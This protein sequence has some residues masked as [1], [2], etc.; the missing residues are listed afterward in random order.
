MI[1]DGIAPD[2]QYHS[3]KINFKWSGGGE[4]ISWHQ[5]AQFRPHT[6]YTDLTIGVYFDDVGPAHRPMAVVPLSVHDELHPLED[7]RGGWTGRLAE[8]ALARIPL[9]A[10][11]A[12]EG[13][14]G[15]LTAHNGR[16]VHGSGPNLS[17]VS[18]P[19]FLATFSSATAH[20]LD[21]GTNPLHL[22]AKRP[23]Q[24]VRGKA[25]V[26]AVV[27]PRPN[28]MAPNFAGGYV[29]PFFDEKT[30]ARPAAKTEAELEAMM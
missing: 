6:N 14:A 12:L 18:R 29:A 21:A 16:C 20:L 13:P 27:D 19:F 28:P 15:T 11:V 17:A 8:D 22:R 3:S 24:I 9:D 5:D 30:G 1:V 10:A 23:P 2:V 25:A 4:A 26:V 7:A